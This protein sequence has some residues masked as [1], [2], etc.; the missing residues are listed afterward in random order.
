LRRNEDDWADDVDEGLVHVCP[1]TD[2][3]GTS[4][5]RAAYVKVGFR[6]DLPTLGLSD[7]AIALWVALASWS[8]ECETDGHVPRRCLRLHVARRCDRNAWPS[9]DAAGLWAPAADG[10]SLATFLARTRPGL[11]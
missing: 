7:R 2:N 10:G 11:A 4:I 5:A 9:S 3:R 8:A 6:S 1:A